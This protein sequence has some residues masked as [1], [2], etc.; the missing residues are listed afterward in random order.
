LYKV[1]PLFRSGVRCMQNR[2]VLHTEEASLF[3][4]RSTGALEPFL[5]VQLLFE[6]GVTYLT[7][8]WAQS[9]HLQVMPSDEGGT[10]AV[11]WMRLLEHLGQDFAWVALTGSCLISSIISDPLSFLRRDSTAFRAISRRCW[12][13][14][15][16]FYRQRLSCRPCDLGLPHGGF[17]LPYHDY[18]PQRRST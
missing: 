18:S 8:K 3:S 13:L 9:L 14:V 17:S 16:S 2:R 6:L 10:V 4:L 12:P 15:S 1:H 5:H 11:N 7:Q